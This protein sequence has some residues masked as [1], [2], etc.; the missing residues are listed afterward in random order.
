MKKT[1]SMA[2]LLLLVALPVG[3]AFTPSLRVKVWGNEKV[4]T[5]N[6]GSETINDVNIVTSNL[7]LRSFGNSKN[8]GPL[9]NVDGTKI[10]R[11][12]RGRVTINTR[13]SG[14]NEEGKKV[15]YSFKGSNLKGD[16]ELT[17]LVGGSVL[18]SKMNVCKSIT[19]LGKQCGK[20]PVVI[21]IDFEDKTYTLDNGFA[22]SDPINSLKG[23]I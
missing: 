22:E 9:S 13:I 1:I 23:R 21:N 8:V 16:G 7:E 20:I 12:T 11:T 6:I 2:L 5:F 18:V 15:T 10:D 4:D 19:G 14:T 3:L 17:P